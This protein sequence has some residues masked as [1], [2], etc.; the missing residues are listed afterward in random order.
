M[1]RNCQY[2][3]LYLYLIPLMAH[4]PMLAPRTLLPNERD[5]RQVLYHRGV[6]PIVLISI[7]GGRVFDSFCKFINDILSAMEPDLVRRSLFDIFCN[8]R[9]DPLAIPYNVLYLSRK[10]DCTLQQCHRVSGVANRSIVSPRFQSLNGTT[11]AFSCITP[12]A[13]N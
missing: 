12:G 5:L 3:C 11:N 10:T 7:S 4:I 6:A 13:C 9:R 1:L 8:L 2:L